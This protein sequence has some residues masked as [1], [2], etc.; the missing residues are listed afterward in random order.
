[1]YSFGGG[2]AEKY[3]LRG[4]I[5]SATFVQMGATESLRLGFVPQYQANCDE[6]LSGFGPS[7]A[8]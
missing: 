3:F 5:P 8:P 1:M 6:D 4:Q 7:E 2:G